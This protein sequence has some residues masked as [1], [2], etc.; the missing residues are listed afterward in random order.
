MALL[1][2]IPV[3]GSSLEHWYD[4]NVCYFI[5]Y[6]QC[7]LIFTLNNFFLALKVHNAEK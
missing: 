3:D 5:Y 6:V 1:S 4:S 7:M 2:F